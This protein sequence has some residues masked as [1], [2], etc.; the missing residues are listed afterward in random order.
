MPCGEWWL[1]G[2]I[3]A[4]AHLVL[5]VEPLHHLCWMKLESLGSLLVER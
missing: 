5:T 1:V 4:E 3:G 2:A